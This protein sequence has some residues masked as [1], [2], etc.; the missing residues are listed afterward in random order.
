MQ[1]DVMFRSR[2]VRALQPAPKDPVDVS[3]TVSLKHRA[4]R[5]SPRHRSMPP[6]SWSESAQL[7]KSPAFSN[8]K[9]LLALRTGLQAVPL[10]TRRYRVSRN[11]G[12]LRSAS[13]SA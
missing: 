7:A 11:V 5:D 13:Y 4:K 9:H 3:T 10:L 6:R 1:E 8:T 2:A 12:L